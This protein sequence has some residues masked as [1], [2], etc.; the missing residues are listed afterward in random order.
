MI[1]EELDIIVFLKNSI[2][3]EANFLFKKKLT[4]C[5]INA[6]QFSDF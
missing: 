4:S 5:S 1:S 6:M 3:W 2:K